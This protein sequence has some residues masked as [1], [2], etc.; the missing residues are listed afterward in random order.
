[1]KITKKLL[2]AAAFAYLVF[3]GMACCKEPTTEMGVYGTLGKLATP[4]S[5]GGTH[6]IGDTSKPGNFTAFI[7]HNSDIIL[8]RYVGD[9]VSVMGNFVGPRSN[10]TTTELVG[11]VFIQVF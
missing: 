1:M 4:L 5:N 9:T 7:S 6:F 3:G 10:G 8:D 11:V 2:L